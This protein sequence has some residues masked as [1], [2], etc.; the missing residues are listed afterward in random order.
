MKFVLAS[1]GTRGDVEPCVAIGRELLHR[2]HEVRMAVSPDQVGFAGSV[3]LS[4]VAY[5]PDTRH[6]QEVHRSLLTRISRRFWRF[7]E[8]RG[9]VREDW[10]LLRH[11]W[12]DSN[13]VLLSLAEEADVLF[14]GVLGE[15]SAA[16]VAQYH[17]IPLATL[18]TYPMRPNSQLNPMLPAP[19]ARSAMKASEWV[20]WKLTKRL[21]DEQRRELGL[22]KATEPTSQRITDRR[23]LELQAYEEVFFPELTAEW[24][25][26]AGHR[27]IVGA[28]TLELPGDDDDEASAWIAAGTPPIFFGFGSMPVRSAAETLSMISKACAQLGERALVGS[29][30]T[31]F[32]DIPHHDN[33][34]VVGTLNYASTFEGCSAVVHHGGLGTTTAGLRAGVPSL[35][36]WTWADQRLWGARVKRLKLGTARRFTATSP[37]TLITDLRTILDPQYVARAREI[38]RQVS[39]P[40]ESVTAAADLMEDLALSRVD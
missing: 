26:F 13:R 38:A 25:P 4:A 32:S 22:S 36:L 19:L 10:K 8:L 30:W 17:E 16:N 14:T 11:L 40:G 23:S 24:A 2:G 5:G 28:L 3:G 15:Q 9:L 7:K 27:P 39:K 12:E 29:G 33:V 6:W 31:D 1:Y 35:I 37:Q 34:K 18:H 20:A 21:D